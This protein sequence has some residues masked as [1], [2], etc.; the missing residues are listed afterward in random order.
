LQDKKNDEPDDQET[1]EIIESFI[2][3]LEKVK[4]EK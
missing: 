1:K 3:S 2:K 4:I